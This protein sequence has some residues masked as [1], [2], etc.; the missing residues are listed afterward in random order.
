MKA[1]AK[2]QLP[3]DDQ[4]MSIWDHLDELRKRFFYVLI[5]LI[6]GTVISFS[7][8]QYFLEILSRPIGG[9]QKLQ[10]IEVSEQIGVYMRVALLSG[11]IL[12]MPV[13]VYQ[14]LGFILPGLTQSEKKWINMA[15][16]T[17]SLLFLSGVLFSYFV[18]LPSAVPFLITF[19]PGLNANIRLSNYVDFVTNLMFWIG[20]AFETPLLVFVLAKFR[21]VNAP[22]LAKQWRIAVVIIAVIAAA[23]TP[24]VD[25]VNM[26]LLMVPLF[27]LYCLSILLASI[28]NPTPK[29]SADKVQ[30]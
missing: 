24:T 5:A 19:I 10:T 26:S 3:Q 23:V 20:I 22:M 6:G 16:P 29:K 9:L 8:T 21:I 7:V 17:A 13:V 11:L 1:M 28:A 18:M 12:A 2:K 4:E 25:P 27:L 30:S 14:L 15:V